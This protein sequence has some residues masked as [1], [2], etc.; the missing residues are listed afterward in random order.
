MLVYFANQR[1]Y[2]V[3]V[4]AAMRTFFPIAFTQRCMLA[5]LLN[6]VLALGWVVWR[7]IEFSQM[8]TGQINE[9][10]LKERSEYKPRTK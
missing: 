9:L 2:A 8:Q 10:Q 6:G 1:T 7:E 5:V 3:M 4:I